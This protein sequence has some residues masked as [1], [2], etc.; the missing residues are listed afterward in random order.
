MSGD[1]AYDS[2]NGADGGSS[3]PKGMLDEAAEREAFRLAV[4]EWRGVG[5]SNSSSAGKTVIVREWEQPKTRETKQS[6]SSA[7]QTGAQATVAGNMWSNPF[8]VNS[9]SSISDLISDNDNDNDAVPQSSNNSSSNN[10][11]R[12]YGGGGRGGAFAGGA[13]SPQTANAASL[14]LSQQLLNGTLDEELEHAVSVSRLI[15]DVVVVVV[16]TLFSS[17]RNLSRL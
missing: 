10:V 9:D 1:A 16:I 12:G 7:A 2:V 6:A 15:A 17:H 5:N 3:Y 4:L 13:A 11:K 8:G 14:P